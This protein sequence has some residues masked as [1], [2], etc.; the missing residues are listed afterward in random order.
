[1]FIFSN[2]TLYAYLLLIYW[3]VSGLVTSGLFNR[4]SCTKTKGRRRGKYTKDTNLIF[5]NH[6]VKCDKI[7]YLVEIHAKRKTI[8]L[9]TKVFKF[10]RNI[11]YLNVGL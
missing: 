3:H 7:E 6:I 1:M 9:E 11:N 2:Y 4:D 8:H 5:K 10:N